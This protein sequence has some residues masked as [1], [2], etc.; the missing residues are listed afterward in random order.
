[1]DKHKFKI[2]GLIISFENKGR[3]FSPLLYPGAF[4]LENL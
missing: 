1:M 2:R 3:D 4:T